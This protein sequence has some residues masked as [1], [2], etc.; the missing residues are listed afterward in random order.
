MKLKSISFLLLTIF[1]WAALG[2]G[3]RVDQFGRQSETALEFSKFP[4][5]SSL[6]DKTTDLPKIQSENYLYT[7]IEK[8][9]DPKAYIVGPGD[10][11]GIN[12]NSIENLNFIVY[13]G[14][15]GDILIPTVGV[16][17]V[18]KLVL[19]DVYEKIK[20]TIKEKY[21]SG[22]VHVY[23]QNIREYKIQISGAVNNPGFYVV[24]PLTRL[25]EIIILAEGFHPFAKEFGIEISDSGSV[26]V[27]NFLD[28][29]ENGNLDENPTIVI[30]QKIY[31]PFGDFQNEGVSIRG[32]EGIHQYDIIQK[33]ETLGQFLRRNDAS[34]SDIN[35][36]K[37]VI[38]RY[39]NSRQEISFVEP[40][41]L[42]TFNLQ[43]GDI[44]EHIIEKGV[45]V[46]GFVQMPGSYKFFPGY[47]CADYI[48]LAGGNS[49]E[50]SL[51]KVTIIHADGTT[52]RG[53]NVLI[54]RGD[55]IIVPRSLAQWLV[56][57]SSFF[58]IIATMASVYM[59]YLAATK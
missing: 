31:V 30:G 26:R 13:V 48:G 52:E 55:Q 15:T 22:E 11:F 33:N 25:H 53:T 6:I 56:G 29:L 54:R 49:K 7:P 17:K 34:L 43:S 38:K 27:V 44:I 4:V 12:I 59:S 28:F 20:S 57:N 16:I 10:Q 36:D 40:E 45:T 2:Y 23:L 37:L 21:K 41:E 46:N 58:Q 35:F 47:T 3:Q 18:D 42:F 24:N 9:I 8:T 39:G 19:A 51:S 50:G 14:P 5:K 1:F 32:I